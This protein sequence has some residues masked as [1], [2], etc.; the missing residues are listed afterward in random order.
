MYRRNAQEPLLQTHDLGLLAICVNDGVLTDLARS[1]ENRVGH[2]T[3]V[4][5]PNVG[6]YPDIPADVY[7][8]VDVMVTLDLAERAVE[9]AQSVMMVSEDVRLLNTLN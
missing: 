9:K 5:Y 1:L 3:R 2:H 8:E 7:S 4:R 6:S